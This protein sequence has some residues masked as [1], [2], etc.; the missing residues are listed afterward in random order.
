MSDDDRDGDDSERANTDDLEPGFTIV[1]PDCGHEFD[2]H[3][4][5][6]IVIGPHT[7]LY[8]CSNCHNTI[9]GPEPYPRDRDDSDNSDTD[10][11]DESN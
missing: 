11:S 5:L 10:N 6:H 7:T 2:P 8:T 9:R 3:D 1:C 4:A